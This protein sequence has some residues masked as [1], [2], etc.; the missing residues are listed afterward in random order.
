MSRSR[1]NERLL[2]TSQIRPCLYSIIRKVPAGQ[3]KR[4]RSSYSRSNTLSAA[5]RQAPTPFPPPH[6]C[7]QGLQAS[8]WHPPI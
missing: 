8:L 5:S 4:G 1:G 7:G 6:S 2:F 3:L